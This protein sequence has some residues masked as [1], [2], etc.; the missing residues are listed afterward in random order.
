[1]LHA[2]FYMHQGSGAF[3]GMCKSDRMHE[4]EKTDVYSQDTRNIQENFCSGIYEVDYCSCEE[5][6]EEKE[7]TSV[8]FWSFGDNIIIECPPL[9]SKN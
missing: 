6:E 8:K 2:I 9:I 7:W 1:M 3:I 4:I 5:E